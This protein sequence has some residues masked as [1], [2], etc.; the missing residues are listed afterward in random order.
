[1]IDRTKLFIV[2]ETWRGEL[3]AALL[4]IFLQGLVLPATAIRP[5]S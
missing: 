1:M 3:Q 2:V 4:V 5:T